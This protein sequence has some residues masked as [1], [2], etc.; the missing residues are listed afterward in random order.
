M[1]RM[2][3]AQVSK[4]TVVHIKDVEIPQPGPKQLVIRVVVSGSNPKDWY[5]FLSFLLHFVSDFIF[6]LFCFGCLCG[7]LKPCWIQQ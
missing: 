7:I 6:S 3:E 1:A 4:G 5:V 2:K